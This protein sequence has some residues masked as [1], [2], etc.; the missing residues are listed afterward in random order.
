MRPRLL[1]IPEAAAALGIS[2]QR[3]HVL[4]HGGRLPATRVGHA[5][6]IAER[7]LDGM[8][9]RKPGRPRK[10]LAAP[11]VL[12]ADAVADPARRQHGPDAD[13]DGQQFGHHALSATSSA[14]V[15]SVAQPPCWIS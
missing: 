8:Q 1:S 9:E 4:I 11:S 6:V 13:G 2:R 12:E 5:W 14:Y 10:G 15:L 7:D 3:V